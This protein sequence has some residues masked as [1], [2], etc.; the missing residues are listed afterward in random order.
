MPI[1]IA[2]SGE[3]STFSTC[4]R[5]CG[6]G[7]FCYQNYKTGCWDCVKQNI[8]VHNCANSTK[9][10]GNLECDH[11]SFVERS[12]IALQHL[13]NTPIIGSALA[14]D[15]INIQTTEGDKMHIATSNGRVLKVEEG[16]DKNSTLIIRTDQETISLLAANELSLKTAFN[17]G[18]ISIES[19]DLLT[20]IKL[21]CYKLVYGVYSFFS[22]D[23]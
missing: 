18:K 13:V 23:T 1:C 3:Y 16:L 12:T 14:N 2:S 19:D 22:S 9:V 15:K 8:V 17:T 7:A 20:G 21:W 11:I 10:R 6:V 5:A 4:Q